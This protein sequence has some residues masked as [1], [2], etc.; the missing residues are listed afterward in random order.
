MASTGQNHKPEGNQAKTVPRATPLAGSARAKPLLQTKP[1]SQNQT[2]T[3]P[4]IVI[5]YAPTARDDETDA[6]LLTAK[7]LDY[8]PPWLFSLAFHLFMLIVM[9]LM[10]YA[11][12]R[13]HKPIQ[14]KV[15]TVY[16]EKLGSQ[17]EFDLP[18]DL[19]AGSELSAVADLFY[20]IRAG[21][22]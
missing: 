2:A 14:L 15:D 5:S 10:F 7:V 21:G 11:V 8:S 19:H 13:P 6:D 17:L 9:G 18:V 1:I 3:P 20:H 12:N 16:A 22:A 4:Q